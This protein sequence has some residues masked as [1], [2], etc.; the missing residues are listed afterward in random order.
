MTSTQFER[1]MVLS[2]KMDRAAELAERDYTDTADLTPAERSEWREL[3]QL[4]DDMTLPCPSS[5]LAGE[6]DG[7]IGIHSDAAW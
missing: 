2:D 4:V 7:R 6:D 5:N 1:W 3:R